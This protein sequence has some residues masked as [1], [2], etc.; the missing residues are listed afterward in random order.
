[1]HA[2]GEF[3]VLKPGTVV[4]FK[5]V[6]AYNLLVRRALG[7]IAEFA[8]VYKTYQWLRFTTTTQ[9][10]SLGGSARLLIGGLFIETTP[11]IWPV[12]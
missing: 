4:P 2:R 6:L 9:T 1:M 11:S 10:S 3:A 12:N 8:V 7:E 5:G